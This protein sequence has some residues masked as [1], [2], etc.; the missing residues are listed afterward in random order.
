M[1]QGN[2]FLNSLVQVLIHSFK[3]GGIEQKSAIKGFTLDQE[4][5]NILNHESLT[6]IVKNELR[7]LTIVNENKITREMKQIVNKYN[8]KV[9]K[10]GYD[11]RF[12]KIVPI[13]PSNFFF[14]MI[15]SNNS[16]FQLIFK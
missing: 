3:Y 15:L 7:E 6:N 14:Q 8:E 16:F 5:E 13:I 2:Q 11:K 9:F 10:F 4:N 1:Y 12:L